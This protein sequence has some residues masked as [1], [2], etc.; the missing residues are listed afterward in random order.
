[1]QFHGTTLKVFETVKPLKVADNN[2]HSKAKL[3]VALKRIPSLSR[4]AS[5]TSSVRRALSGTTSVQS[6]LAGILKAFYSGEKRSNEAAL[7]S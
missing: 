7:A 4:C 2:L 3:Y 6:N 1:M 5:V